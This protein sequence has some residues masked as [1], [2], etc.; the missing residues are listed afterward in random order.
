[1]IY[2]YWR[3]RCTWRVQSLGAAAAAQM[4]EYHDKYCGAAA[5]SSRLR[6]E[7]ATLRRTLEVRLLPRTATV[8]IG[9]L[10]SCSYCL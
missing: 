1:M 6:G 8:C 10:L 9:R 5:E 3:P 7:I 2:L 4:S